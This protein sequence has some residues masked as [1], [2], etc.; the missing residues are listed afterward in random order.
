ML[1]LI[2]KYMDHGFTD[3]NWFAQIF[4]FFYALKRVM[5]QIKRIVTIFKIMLKESL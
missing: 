3:L 1:V 4:N 5:P 2:K